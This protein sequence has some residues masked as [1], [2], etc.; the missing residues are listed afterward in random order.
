MT[1]IRV[2]A[3]SRAWAP[4]ERRIGCTLCP[5]AQVRYDD[6][7]D[8]LPDSRTGTVTPIE[9]ASRPGLAGSAQRSA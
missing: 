5:A 3:V 8:V 6:I 2:G 9:E 4:V 7:R 1:P